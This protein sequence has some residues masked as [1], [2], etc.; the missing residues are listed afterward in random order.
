MP[1]NQPPLGMENVKNVTDSDNLLE[2]YKTSREPHV[3]KPKKSKW[4]F[5]LVAFCLITVL[6]IVCAFLF[7]RFRPT[8]YSP[9]PMLD[10][11]V[12]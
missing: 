6:L 8:S 11:V 3:E 5:V 1:E 2:A 4:I 10:E 7:S 9:Q 12:R